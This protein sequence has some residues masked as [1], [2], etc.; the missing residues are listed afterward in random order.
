M[1]SKHHFKMYFTTTNHHSRLL[2]EISRCSGTANQ[3][4]EYTQSSCGAAH[5]LPLHRLLRTLS[6]AYPRWGL[7]ESESGSMRLLLCPS[8]PL[9][10]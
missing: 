2:I 9:G 1:T 3:S 4:S 10:A 5:A 7:G 6:S 8:D